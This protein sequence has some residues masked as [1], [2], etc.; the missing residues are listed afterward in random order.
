MLNRNVAIESLLIDRT[1]IP[2]T[3]W[4]D[5]KGCKEVRLLI[6]LL[7]PVREAEGKDVANA[8]LARIDLVLTNHCRR[9]LVVGEGACLEFDK[10]SASVVGLIKERE[11]LVAAETRTDKVGK[12][13]K[14]TVFALN[15]KGKISREGATHLYKEARSKYAKEKPRSKRK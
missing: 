5:L 12:D 15:T 11:P 6:H 10:D 2:T 13:R 3:E 9:L 1:P 7:H 8:R 14:V 4:L